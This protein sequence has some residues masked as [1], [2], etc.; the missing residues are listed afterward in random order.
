M[1]IFGFNLDLWTIVGFLGQFIFYLR[2]VVQWIASEKKGY[3]Y[4]PKIFWHLSIVGSII[5]SIYAFQRKDLVIFIGTTL[6]VGIYIRNLTL[7]EKTTIK[8]TESRKK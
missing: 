8:T 3:S 5:I 2:F 7:F 6:S 1:K 4:F